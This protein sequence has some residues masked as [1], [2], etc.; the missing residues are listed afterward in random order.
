MADIFNVKDEL[1]EE[2][3]LVDKILNKM[4]MKGTGKWKARESPGERAFR[5]V[6]PLPV[7][8][9]GFFGGGDGNGT[10]ALVGDDKRKVPTGANPLHN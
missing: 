8:G 2:E 3:D 5:D 9:G 7:A 4:G 10:D 1:A 6:S